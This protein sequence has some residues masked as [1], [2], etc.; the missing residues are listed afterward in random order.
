LAA[1]TSGELVKAR[2]ARDANIPET[3]L[4]PYLDLL[5]TLYLIHTLPAWGNNL[6]KR[7]TG[8]PKV[9]LLDTGLAA[10]LNNVTPAGM[11]PNAVSDP[12]GGLLESFVAAEL[13]RQLV[14]ARTPAQLFH[15]RDRNGM[16]IDIVIESDDRRVAGVEMKASG[17]A[18]ESDFRHLISL[19]DKLGDRFMLGV[20]FHTGTSAVPFGDRLLALPYSALWT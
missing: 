18:S 13:R 4:D 12:A 11:A 7:V 10:R 17:S 6:T 8:R 15:F 9:A 16:E 2:V 1:N 19:R 14:W 5:E 20:V 3:S